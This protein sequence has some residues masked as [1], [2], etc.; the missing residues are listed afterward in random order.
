[1]ARRH[2]EVLDLLLEAILEGRYPTGAMLPGEE[3]LVAEFDVSRGT[4]REALRALEERNVAKVK[5]GR[6]ATVQPPEEWNVLDP[7]VVRALARSRARRTFLRELSEYRLMLESEAAVLAA[8]RATAKQR[9]EL[10]AAA[11]E[12]GESS[13]AAAAARRLR[14]LVAIASGNRPL[15][16]TLRALS[17]GNEP[18]LRSQSAEALAALADAVADGDP[19][20]ARESAKAVHAAASA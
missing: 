12:L 15:A 16:S 17:E 1:V 9:A 20:R 10:R 7:V 8:E 19:A 11:R 2:R 4:A 6:G 5:H 13:D 18:T 3:A 14:R